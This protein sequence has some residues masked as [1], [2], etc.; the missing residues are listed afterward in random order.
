MYFIKFF[1]ENLFTKAC[2]FLWNALKNRDE[3][4][5]RDTYVIKHKEENVNYRIQVMGAWV[6]TANFNVS[7]GLKIFIMK[8]QEKTRT[9]YL[10]SYL[11]FGKE[12]TQVWSPT[13]VFQSWS[14]P[15]RVRELVGMHSPPTSGH[16]C[17]HPQGMPSLRDDNCHLHI[18]ATTRT[19]AR[20]LTLI[21]SKPDDTWT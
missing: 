17:T 4:R 10:L 11:A 12:V 2:Q 19:C 15:G 14:H 7:M 16:H 5:T 8:C 9:L 13:W 20:W 3:F 21:V 6:L 1:L 18:S